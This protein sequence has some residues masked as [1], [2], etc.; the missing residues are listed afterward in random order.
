M[1]CSLPPVQV[2]LQILPI[3]E[4]LPHIL[5]PIWHLPRPLCPQMLPA[6]LNWHLIKNCLGGSF[7]LVSYM[8]TF[9]AYEFVVSKIEL[10]IS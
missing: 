3:L 7:V 10:Q 9:H 1:P 4:G 6:L 2:P 5:P 8:L